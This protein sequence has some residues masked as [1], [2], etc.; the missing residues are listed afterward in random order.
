MNSWFSRVEQELPTLLEHLSSHPVCN[1]VCVTRSLVLC[2]V[3]CRLLFFFY[4]ALCCLFFDLQILITPLDQLYYKMSTLHINCAINSLINTLETLYIIF[5]RWP[6]T[7]DKL[8]NTFLL[9]LI[10]LV[11][12]LSYY[13][14][15]ME[16]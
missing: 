8:Q 1:V 6:Q 15:N 10:L 12:V 2:V 4:W 7:S 5:R 9:L 11:F 14:V 16:S 3:F 13:V